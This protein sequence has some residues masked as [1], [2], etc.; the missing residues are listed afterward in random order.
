MTKRF[1]MS[2]KAGDAH[3]GW[4][5]IDAAAGLSEIER[6]ADNVNVTRWQRLHTGVHGLV[7]AGCL[8]VD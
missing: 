5:H 6:Y 2:F 1:E 4:A 8:C 3:G 7:A